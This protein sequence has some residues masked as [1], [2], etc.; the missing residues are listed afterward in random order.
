MSEKRNKIPKAYDVTSHL[1]EELRIERSR[2]MGRRAIRI[3]MLNKVADRV[4][5]L[6]DNAFRDE[7]DPFDLAQLPEGPEDQKRFDE[8]IEQYKMTSPEVVPMAT[9][10]PF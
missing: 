1:Q 7:Y 10:R 8:Y 9:R 5:T 6:I 3:S 4:I 2:A